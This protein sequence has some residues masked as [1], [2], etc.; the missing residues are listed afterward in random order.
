MPPCLQEPP[1]SPVHAI[2]HSDPK[3]CAPAEG[4]CSGHPVQSGQQAGRTLSD[5]LVIHFICRLQ[6]LQITT[7][8]ADVAPEQV[9]QGVC[10]H[11][12]GHFDDYCVTSMPNNVMLCMYLTDSS[13]A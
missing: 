2:H 6:L 13:E 11:F 3:C 5:L 4:L 12:D 10:H 8:A 1:A 9:S 7:Q